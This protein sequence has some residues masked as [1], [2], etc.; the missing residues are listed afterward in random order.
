MSARNIA[1][2][3][4]FAAVVISPGYAASEVDTKPAEPAAAAPMPMPMDCGKMARHDHGVERGT[5]TPAMAMMKCPMAG[6]DTTAPAA[7]V[8]KAKG[9]RGHDHARVHKLM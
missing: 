6:E 2:V 8:K 7:P 9:K 1:L 3:I 5:P 4:A